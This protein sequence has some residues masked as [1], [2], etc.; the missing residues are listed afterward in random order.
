M[1]PPIEVGMTYDEV[2]KAFGLAETSVSEEA[3]ILEYTIDNQV[4]RVTYAENENGQLVVCEVVKY[5]N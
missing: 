2:T 3:I 5:K 4:Y 1:Q